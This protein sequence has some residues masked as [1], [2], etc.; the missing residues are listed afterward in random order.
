MILILEGIG[1]G[2]GLVGAYFVIKK[3]RWGFML[4]IVSNCF[5]VPVFIKRTLWFTVLLFGVYTIV[6]F[7]GFY[8]WSKKKGGVSE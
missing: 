5:L 3:N 4:W 6:N 2:L 1:V 7:C 8:V